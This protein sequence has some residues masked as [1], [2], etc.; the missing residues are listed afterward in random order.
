MCVLL[1]GCSGDDTMLMVRKCCISSEIYFALTLFVL[2]R[3]HLD[4]IDFYNDLWDTI[5]TG[6]GYSVV[7]KSNPI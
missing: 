4:F 2:G 6:G 7:K 1:R 3:S 5:N